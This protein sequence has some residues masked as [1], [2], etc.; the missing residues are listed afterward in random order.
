MC[1][2]IHVHGCSSLLFYGLLK[3]GSQNN[4][5]AALRRTGIFPSP[6]AFDSEFTGE[7]YREFLGDTLTS[8]FSLV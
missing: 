2:A 6:A 3:D 5:S 8:V 4:V 1:H 7:L